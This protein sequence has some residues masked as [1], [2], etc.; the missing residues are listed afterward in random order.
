MKNLSKFVSGGQLSAYQGESDVCGLHTSGE[1]ISTVGTSLTQRS[2]KLAMA[3]QRLRAAILQE[4]FGVGRMFD[5]AMI[6]PDRPLQPTTIWSIK[7][8]SIESPGRQ[9]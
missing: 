6:G 9:A 8:R 5:R 7:I 2:H 4:A 3:T 1:I